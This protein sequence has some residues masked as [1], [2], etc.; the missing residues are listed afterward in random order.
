MYL[1]KYIFLRDGII[2]SLI[3]NDDVLDEIRSRADIVD[4][5]SEYVNLKKR[6]ANYMGLCP[7]H[8]EKT[9]SFSV[10]PSKQIFHCFGCHA[11]GDVITFVM[12][13]ENMNFRE[14]CIFLADKY[15]IELAESKQNVNY[16]EETNKR[17]RCYEANKLAA[18]YFMNK[19]RQNKE[20]LS[21]LKKRD[22]QEKTINTF[23]L[24]YSDDS[25][26]G[27]KNFLKS[28]GF[29]EEE[30]TEYNLISKSDKGKY[31]DR[32]RN[33]IM[34]PIIDTKKRV[35]GFGGR[36][37]DKSEPKYLNSR[38]TVVFHKGRNL[39]NLNLVSQNSERKRILLVEGYMDVISLYKSGI[40]YSVASLGTALTSD[41][42]KIIKRYGQEVL[43]CYDGDAAGIKATQRAIEI[44]RSEDIAP[45][46]VS[47][48]NNLDPDEYIKKY[49]KINFELCL[50]EAK[51]FM[52]YKIENIKANFDL[53]SSLGKSNFTTEVAK[54]IS[55]LKNPIERD[56]Y[57]TKI[58]S[59]YKI[60]R[61]AIMN[62]ISLYSKN[63]GESKKNKLR[64]FKTEKKFIKPKRIFSGK[65]QRELLL[66][67][68]AL[69]SSD[70]Y[71]NLK[72]KLDLE[73]FEDPDA[74]RVFENLDDLYEKKVNDKIG[75]LLEKKYISE[76][77]K[78]QL[79]EV[80]IDTYNADA[81]IKDLVKA[82]KINKIEQ[83][84][85]EI[86]NKIKNFDPKGPSLED[87]SKKLTELNNKLKGGLYD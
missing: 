4:L 50:K 67:K 76:S 63:Y 52:D 30:L 74:K 25:W 64:S 73:D 24:G 28:K 81:I 19:L 16:K 6:G 13:R 32:F 21:Y 41:Q 66:I 11:G 2:V 80:M 15:G 58:S 65:N 23:G 12:K 36:V 8:G 54:L 47:L 46:I 35:L 84:R 77:F 61:Q 56:V 59:E 9:P 86:L 48:P 43:I 71:Y 10:S 72:A 1:Q 42:A 79:D 83:K 7:F 39:Y 57:I 70:L 69:Y 5:I 49:G 40:N 29:K 55:S 82:I 60:T 27:L 75:Y 26:D 87:L 44:L 68:Y 53:N 62:Y 78:R 33:R 20:A 14:A 31:Y 17:E 85:D 38:D 45:K 51:N 34:F 18:I 3:I 37:M 22:I